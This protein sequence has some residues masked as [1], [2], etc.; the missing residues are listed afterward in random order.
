M[1]VTIL[2]PVYNT[3]PAHLLE[4]VYSILGQDD[5]INHPVILIDD[6]STSELTIK[7]LELL[8]KSSWH[9]RIKLIVK[10]NGGTSSALNEG[11]KNTE[12]EYAAIMGSDDICD[13][14]RFRMQCDY[15]TAHPETDVIGT[16]LFAFYN[17]E[18]SRRPQWTSAH[19][20]KPDGIHN[21]QNWLVNH[22]TVIYRNKAVHDAGLYNLDYKR[23]Q[24]IELWSRMIKKG[25]IFRNITQVLYGWR[26][27]R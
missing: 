20:E 23:G 18:I 15:L 12:T 2:I 8:A 16:N 14:G 24:D 25:H 3:H 5:G 19:K 7:A 10:E 22:G 27:F 11:H 1:K 21:Q 13:R 26:R 4:A 17:D 9:H 6:G